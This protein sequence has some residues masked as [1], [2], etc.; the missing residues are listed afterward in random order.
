MTTVTWALAALGSGI[1]AVYAW[2]VKWHFVPSGMSRGMQLVSLVTLVTLAL[3]LMSLW[4]SPQP[5]R[6]QLWGA[7][8]QAIAAALFGW[9]LASTRAQR[10]TLAFAPDEPRMLICH[11][12]YRFIRHPFY[13]AYSLFWLG[14]CVASLSGL[15]CLSA[16]VLIGLYLWAAWLEEAKFARTGLA[17]EYLT[18]SFHAGLMWPLA[19]MPR[20]GLHRGKLH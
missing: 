10:L 20:G 3:Y 16:V 2:A 9:A 17:E 12:P 8:M 15:V 7:S 13:A 19:G 11:G 18:Y 6:S 4:V 1:F 14:C 5:L